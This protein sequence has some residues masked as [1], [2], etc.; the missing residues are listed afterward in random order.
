[1]PAYQTDVI[2]KN[3]QRTEL[4]VITKN[5]FFFIILQIYPDWYTMQFSTKIK[6]TRHTVTCKEKRRTMKKRKMTRKKIRNFKGSISLWQFLVFCKC[7]IFNML[8]NLI[9][10]Y[11]FICWE[12]SKPKRELLYLFIDFFLNKFLK[13]R[14]RLWFPFYKEET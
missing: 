12:Y 13:V 2:K 7:C 9:G 1:M 11:K 4:L 8:L 6:A 14:Q 10:V 3:M 5:D